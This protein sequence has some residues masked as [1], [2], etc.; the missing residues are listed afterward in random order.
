MNRVAQSAPLPLYSRRSALRL[1]LSLF[2]I[3]GMAS[4]PDAASQP[5]TKRNGSVEY[6][7]D[8]LPLTIRSRRIDNGNGLN[9]H[10][11]ESGCETS[12]RP[13]VVLPHGFPQP[14]YTWRNQLPVS[15]GGG[16]SGFTPTVILSLRG[17]LKPTL[18]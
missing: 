12:H 3:A 18:V 6:A 7:A 1:G 4:N 9:L 16:M 11:L 13:L 5:A 8:T 14:A 15:L 10:L 2:G 17:E